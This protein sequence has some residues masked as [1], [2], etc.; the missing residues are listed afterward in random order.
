MRNCDLV[1]NLRLDFVG[2]NDK[3]PHAGSVEREPLKH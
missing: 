3:E 2:G 1:T